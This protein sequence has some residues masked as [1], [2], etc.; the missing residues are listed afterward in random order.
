[1][2]NGLRDRVQLIVIQIKDFQRITQKCL[3][4]PKKDLEQDR[5][6]IALLRHNRHQGSEPK[7]FT[8]T[9]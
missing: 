3:E 9:L 5:K 6:Q 7:A 2:A 4:T 8:L 1:M